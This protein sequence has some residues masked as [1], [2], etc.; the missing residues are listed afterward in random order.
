LYRELGIVLHR[1][2]CREAAIA[3]YED[4]LKVVAQRVGAWDD[5]SHYDGLQGASLL[6]ALAELPVQTW[7]AVAQ[8]EMMQLLQGLAWLTGRTEAGN[9]SETALALALRL[10]I[11]PEQEAMLW[12][13]RAWFMAIELPVDSRQVGVSA[14]VAAIIEGLQMALARCADATLEPVGRGLVAL[15]Q[16]QVAQ[17]SA[18][19]IDV[20]L[21]PAF[22]E[23]QAL[24]TAAWLWAHTQRETLE[25][26]LAQSPS[27]ASL[28]W[29]MPGTLSL[30]LETLLVWRTR[31]TPLSSAMPW[32]AALLMHQPTATLEALRVLCRPGY[33]PGLQYTSLLAELQRLRGQ[34][35]DAAIADQIAMLLGGTALMER[36]ET[37]LAELDQRLATP[38]TSSPQ[39]VRQRKQRQ[40]RGSTPTAGVAAETTHVLQLIS[41]LHAT[42]QVAESRVPEVIYRWLQHYRHLCMHAPEV[43]GALLG[44]LRQC[45]GAT[46]VIPALLA[47]VA[48]SRRQRQALEATLH[49]PAE[50]ATTAPTLFAWEDPEHWPLG[51]SLE[52][53][54]TIQRPAGMEHDVGLEVQGQY[55]AALV[56]ARLGLVSRAVVRLQACLALQPA[57]PLAHYTLAQF[58]RTQGQQ[59]AALE[60]TLQAWHGLTA[61]GTLPQL[62]HLE[63]LHQ[64]LAL[65]ETTQQYARFPEWFAAFEQ[66]CTALRATPLS[67]TH[68]QRVRAAEGICA[69]LRASYL[70]ATV[71]PLG[72]SMAS[73]TTQQLACVEQAIALGTPLT[74]QRALHRQ[75]EICVRQYRYDAAMTTYQHLVQQWP[76]DQRARQRLDLLSV[77]QLPSPDP[78]VTDR[79]LQE[80]LT[81]AW[82]SA[83]APPMPVPLTPDSV[84]AWLQQAPRHASNVLD[85]LDVLTAYGG[86]AVQ[87]Q[88]WQRAVAVLTP[89]YTLSA[90]PQQAYYLAVAYYAQSQQLAPGKEALHA[91]AQALQ[92]AQ[93][94]LKDAPSLTAAAALLPEMEEN[95]QRLLTVH[96]QEQGRL[97]Y[98][99]RV[100]S[101]FAQHG[102]PVQEHTVPGAPDAA[103]VEVQELADLDEATGKLVT[104]VHLS[105]NGQAVGASIV[106]DEAE[107]TLYAQHQRDKQRLV[108]TYGIEALP[109]PH[110]AYEGSTDFAVLFPERLG[111]NR[112]VLFIAFADL[113]ALIRYARVLRYIAQDLPTSAVA[114]PPPSVN[115]LAAA[116]RYLT[117][118]PLLHQRLQILAAAAPSKVVQRQITSV[119]DTL[120]TGHTSEFLLPF[121]AFADAYIYFHAIV[122]AMRAQLDTPPTERAGVQNEERQLPR[123]ARRKRRQN[124]DRW[125]EGEPE[126]RHESHF[127]DVL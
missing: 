54:H 7:S 21:V 79:I 47:Q 6:T 106:L 93:V 110:T 55:M 27:S 73:T 18:A 84:L 101:I 78:L 13:Q 102:I 48:L 76:D 118:L 41:L 63:I 44:L 83:S 36:L 97:A 33:V 120:P 20:P 121:P 9:L 17:A 15:L 85:V 42:P 96:S 23:L 68:E 104:T 56:L 12:C 91:S 46:A 58:L 51:R 74:Q 8:G 11:T 61:L 105:F 77:V 98:R 111:L 123:P 53:L 99:G 30:A 88:E 24:C 64:L 92:Y 43:V 94:A 50:H 10:A 5:I 67:P 45:P 22:P 124:K 125:R 107:V 49:T 40:R 59:E 37:L 117:L 127:S 87:R 100:C 4:G 70:A 52:T 35:T 80:A 60:H 19:L 89:L 31:S 122:D 113:H 28:P 69:L 39:A 57:H 3:C 62:L 119:C 86:V 75:A 71:P 34:L 114:T 38:A 95:H 90:Q 82:T 116:A 108:E 26:A 14:P 66:T 16:G 115:T 109:W 65:L 32:M 1:L 126:R 112:D 103:W 72:G 25:Q 81:A 2:S 29:Q